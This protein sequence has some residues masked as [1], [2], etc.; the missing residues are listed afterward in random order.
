MTKDTLKRWEPPVLGRIDL[1]ADE[2]LNVGCKTSSG[3]APHM[4][5]GPCLSGV[6]AGEG[7]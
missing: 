1:T 7:S 2:V 3:N 5:S 4:D 6:C